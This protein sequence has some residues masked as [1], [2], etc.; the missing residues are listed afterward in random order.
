[1][2]DGYDDVDTSWEKRDAI[3]HKLLCLP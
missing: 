3:V 2:I 1:L